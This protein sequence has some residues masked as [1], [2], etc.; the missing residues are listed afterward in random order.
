[1][2]I[3]IEIDVTPKEARSTMGLPD[4]E[5]MNAALVKEMQTRLQENIAALS[6]ESLIGQWMGFG[7]KMGEQ[8]MDLMGQVTTPGKSSKP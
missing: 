3:K 6:P 2:K 4:V 8:F 7:G 5:K 1:M